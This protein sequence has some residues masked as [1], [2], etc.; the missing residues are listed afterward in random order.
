MKKSK[1]NLTDRIG[2]IH[3]SHSIALILDS[4]YDRDNQPRHAGYRLCNSCRSVP[5]PNHCNH[6]NSAYRS[7]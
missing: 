3:C 1:K 2:L 4:A 5:G 6:Y 7:I